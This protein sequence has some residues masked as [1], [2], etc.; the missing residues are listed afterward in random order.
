MRTDSLQ[1]V[2][3]PQSYRGSNRDIG[4][5]FFSMYVMVRNISNGK[6]RIPRESFSIVSDAKQYDYIP[7]DFVLGSQQQQ[8]YLDQWQD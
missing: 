1:V 4:N 8:L 6:I 7:L 3:R 5:K 2:V